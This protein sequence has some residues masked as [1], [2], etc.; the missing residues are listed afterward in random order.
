MHFY[1]SRDRALGVILGLGLAL[2]AL[3]VLALFIRVWAIFLVMFTFGLIVVVPM[4]IGIKAG[5]KLVEVWKPRQL[6]WPKLLVTAILLWPTAVCLPFGFQLF[7]LSVI[8]P[9]E[10]PVYPLAEHERTSVEW[11]DAANHGDRVHLF[12]VTDSNSSDIV[13]F[14]RD[15]LLEMS[16]EEGPAHFI[17]WERFGTPYWFN[18]A[19]TGIVHIK[20][21]PAESDERIEFEVIFEPYG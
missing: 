4:Y 13:Q 14:Y 19:R 15:Q 5:L 8:T 7:R 16:W 12:F 1:L 6:G 17:E 2:L 18:K 3:S 10:I 21:R 9:L 20:M 11:G